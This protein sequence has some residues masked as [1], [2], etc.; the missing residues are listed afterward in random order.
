AAAP[1]A[2]DIAQPLSP[3]DIL[4]RVKTGRM[5]PDEAK[6]LLAGMRATADQ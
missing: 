3:R 2:P 5:R 6:R 1:P 4:E